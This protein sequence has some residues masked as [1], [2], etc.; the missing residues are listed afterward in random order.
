MITLTAFVAC[1]WR[2]F[3]PP[4][5]FAE[6]D[7]TYPGN[8]LRWDRFDTRM[9]G[10]PRFAAYLASAPNFHVGRDYKEARTRVRLHK[11]YMV[12][13]KQAELEELDRKQ[14]AE[15]EYS[16]FSIAEDLE[17]YN[18]ERDILIKELDQALR[19]LDEIQ[20]R[21]VQYNALPRLSKFDRNSLTMF[22][23]HRKPICEEEERMFLCGPELV[24][25]S[26]T[27]QNSWLDN[28]VESVIH[29]LPL[30]QRLF[31]PKEYQSVKDDVTFL[32]RRERIAIVST[33]ILLVL[34]VVSMAMPVWLL[35]NVSKSQGA[36]L[37]VVLFFIAS[38]PLLQIACARSKYEV[39]STSTAYAAIIAAFL[40]NAPTLA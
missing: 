9:D 35:F 37:A 11:M 8:K 36:K 5:S 14:C 2:W 17:C 12:E 39:F 32:Y 38:F 6:K 29:R 24:S 22:L 15:D 7:D 34:T 10:Y 19:E 16:V 28:A 13:K 18:S 20:L 33:I 21:E 1:S 23:Y 40:S 4:P 3:F 30:A 25:L 31:I 27:H 26:Q